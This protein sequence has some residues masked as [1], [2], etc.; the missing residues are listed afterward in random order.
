M[1]A[2]D[3]PKHDTLMRGKIHIMNHP[4]VELIIS[5]NILMAKLPRKELDLPRD[6]AL[7]LRGFLTMY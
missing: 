1:R 3:H 7:P 5:I 2:F 4:T 6:M